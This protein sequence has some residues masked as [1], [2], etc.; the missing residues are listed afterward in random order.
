MMDK[1]SIF[2]KGVL[3][4]LA[5]A[6]VDGL[7]SDLSAAP[8]QPDV[9]IVE[10]IGSAAIHG[11]DVA[12][13]REEAISNGLVSALERVVAGQLPVEMQVANFANLNHLFYN[14]TGH[15]IKDYKVMTE[16]MAEKTYRVL[17]Q[18]TI[19]EKM[20]ADQLLTQGIVQE[21]KENPTVAIFI[22]EHNGDLEGIV[23]PD[24]SMPAHGPSRTTAALAMAE[25]MKKNGFTVVD[26]KNIEELTA[27][28]NELETDG[29]SRKNLVALGRRLKADVVIFG[30]SAWEISQNTIGTD[31]KSFKGSVS[32]TALRT[33][34]AA[35]I[36]ETRRNG[37]AVSA[38]EISGSRE[39]LSGAGALAGESLSALIAVQWQ[40]MVP[41][42]ETS[43]D[44]YIEGTETLADFVVFRRIL[45]DTEGVS[46]IRIKEM[47]SDKA[48]L[49]VRFAGDAKK[50]A[51]V[52]IMNR[53]QSFGINIYEVLED[54]LKIALV[55][56]ER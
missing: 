35:D 22:T 29:Y 10:I 48:I 50:L 38:N 43:I 36:A 34:T 3:I 44:I 2:L 23:R 14:Q 28:K 27:Q 7:S 45:N 12:K 53:Y 41:V 4:V 46:N 26:V 18:A 31:I 24:N 9:K 1:S 11:K 37:I 55:S 40:K 16:T 30:R 52:L 32:A 15:Y 42:K 56:E 39:A 33:D 49:N 5:I 51:D 25:T 17:V 6:A 54:Q 20:V 8:P 21:K 13:A 47:A 19:S